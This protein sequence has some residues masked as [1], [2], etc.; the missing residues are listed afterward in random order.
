MDNECILI[1]PTLCRIKVI[2][3]NEKETALLEKA[4]K[5]KGLLETQEDTQLHDTLLG[6]YDAVIKEK[7]GDD[8][9]F[10]DLDEEDG[11]PYKV[12]CI[13]KWTKGIG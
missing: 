1:S 11:Y 8:Y 9:S 12:T 5:R 2:A 4:E 13:V 7:L 3:T 6:L 10:E